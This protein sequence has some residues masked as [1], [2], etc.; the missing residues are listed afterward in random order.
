M[1]RDP[2]F[3]L[4]GKDLRL[5]WR[6]RRALVVLLA[7]PLIMILVLGLSLGEGFGQ[8]ADGL[9]RISVVDLD[10]GF[11]DPDTPGNEGQ[12]HWSR[13]VQQDFSQT[14]GIRVEV[15][16]DRAEAERLVQEGHRAA[17]L[18]FGPKFSRKMT[19]CSFL[20]EGINPLFREGINLQELDAELLRDPTQLTASSIIE[21]VAQ[22]TT[23]R[24]VMPWMIGR[25][26]Q[27]VGER[28]G[29]WVQTGIKQMFPKVDLTGK[30]W[31][32]L[33]RSEPIS[34][35][36]AEIVTYKSPRGE[37]LLNR[38]A[39]SYQIL[40]PSYLV[41][42]S[43][44]LVLTAGRLFVAERQQGTLKRL[45]A[46][47]LPRWKIVGGKL[48]PCLVISVAQG[49]FLLGA[50][51]LVFAMQ[52]GS[53]PAW[54]LMVVLA[55]S[56]SVTGL[57]LLVA[58]LAR[59]ESQVTIYGTLLVLVL[60]GVSGCLMGDRELMPEAMQRASL[61]TPHA[62]ALVAYRQLL[63]N[64]AGPNLQLVG[65]ACAVL[66]VYGIGLIVLAWWLMR[67]DGEK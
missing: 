8:K 49:L 24:V 23:L 9:L 61:A 54:L 19:E 10:E 28:F 51:K 6:D 5:V 65:Q 44:F 58:A 14:A 2:I 38:G 48:I 59:T 1:L 32:A 4:A 56:L 17:V 40:V 67:L 15:I 34:T 12:H 57:T 55:T 25:A 42:F 3:I 50:G 47:P 30:T 27:K 20:A 21:Q 36:G 26:F 35:P 13:V 37:G 18:V 64:P 33:T 11:T 7:M 29:S 62:W 41:M 52:W 45:R 53:Q 22:V 43:Y 60:A 31:A 63:A 46:A 16:T 39:M 66:S